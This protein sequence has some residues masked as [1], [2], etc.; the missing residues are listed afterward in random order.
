MEK[1][2]T[3]AMEERLAEMGRRLATL[4]AQLEAAEGE[5][6]AE[7]EKRI[8]AASAGQE[9]Q[10]RRLQRLKDAGLDRWDALKDEAGQGWE[11]LEKS[12]QDLAAKLKKKPSKR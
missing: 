12:L 9:E 8:D 4:K 2:D 7:L 3:A 10:R 1:K 6:K 5:V 11:E